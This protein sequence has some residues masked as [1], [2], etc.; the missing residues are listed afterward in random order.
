M[1]ANDRPRAILIC[2]EG[3]TE[4]LYFD[5]IVRVFDVNAVTNV[6]I[7]GEVGQLKSL[8]DKCVDE[9]IRLA[10]EFDLRENEVETWAVCDDDKRKT[11]YT[12]LLKYSNSK[13]V[14]LAYARPQ[15]ES[16]LLQHFEQSKDTKRPIM[17]AKLTQYAN[18][19]GFSGEYEKVAL[20]WLE[21]AILMNPTIVSTAIVNSDQRN[22][23]TSD[24][25][26]TVQRLT[27]RLKNLGL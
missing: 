23:H 14:N 3:K 18:Q 15:F 4:K 11:T 13:D 8:V 19:N 26:L 25:F 5:I 6:E 21:N 22:K 2:S 10:Q 27:E 12:D 16:Y 20:D 1:N 7:L 17:F 9:R 24:P